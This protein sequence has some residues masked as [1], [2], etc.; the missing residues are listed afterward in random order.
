MRKLKLL[1]AIMCTCFVF[2]GA[3]VAFAAYYNDGG[4]Y[5][6]PNLLNLDMN[7]EQFD[8][9]VEINNSYFV[10][11][12]TYDQNVMFDY[13]LYD[14]PIIGDSFALSIWFSRKLIE[15]E[16]IS[17]EIYD[18]TGTIEMDFMCNNYDTNIYNNYYTYDSVYTYEELF[19]DF[20]FTSEIEF[21]VSLYH[22][23]GYYEIP[24]PFG[25][26]Y[27]EGAYED[28]YQQGV[29]DGFVSAN[30]SGLWT[31]ID[32]S[33]IY[34][35]LGVELYADDYDTLR[36]SNVLFDGQF[37][38]NNYIAEYS[39]NG[40]ISY[41]VIDLTT[42]YN[43]FNLDLKVVKGT[44]SIYNIKFVDSLNNN[45]VVSLSADNT[46]MIINS[47]LLYNLNDIS[48]I[49]IE[50]VEQVS[51][52]YDY[53]YIYDNR[54]SAYNNGYTSGYNQGVADGYENGYTIGYDNGYAE[55]FDIGDTTGYNRGYLVGQ[56][57][58]DVDMSGF[59][60]LFGGIVGVPLNIINSLMAI[61]LFNIPII[62]II[63][64]LLLIALVVF[65]IKKFIVK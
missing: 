28:H 33:I 52:Q 1:I 6:N 23:N 12:T 18:N 3:N 14:N 32:T 49:V 47:E 15:N 5:R 39:F 63:T 11:D 43:I 44:D 9:D 54:L 42:P 34:N 21:V 62:S 58:V 2:F 19:F 10:C 45:Y 55:G 29:A 22:Y 27:S 53:G 48:S 20:V 50:F 41:I 56:Q 57:S 31:L 24:M 51:E 65:V 17:I 40:D 59:D 35:N 8:A 7:L 61:T 4:E 46:N 64:T 30:T 38:I 37:R 25:D 13:F 26:F 36:D 60:T 16:F